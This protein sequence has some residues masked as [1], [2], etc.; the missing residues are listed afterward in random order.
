MS[1]PISPPPVTRWQPDYLPAYVANGVIGLR[2]GPVPHLRGVAIVSGFEG[3]DSTELI[4]SFARAPYPVAADL[5]VGKVKLSGSPERATLH[6]QRYDFAA[7]ELHTRMSF[8]GDDAR[9]EVDVLT[10][11]SRTLPTIALQEIVVRVDRDCDLMLSAGVDTERLPGTWGDRMINRFDVDGLLRWVSYGGTG[12]CGAAYVTELSGAEHAGQTVDAGAAAPLNTSYTIRA[13]A[14]RPY[15]LRQLTSLVPDALHRQ[16]HLQAVRLAHA[17]RTRGFDELRRDNART[18]DDLWQGRVVLAGAPRR[19]QAMAD[20][21][22]FYL[23]TSVHRSSP[24][25][26]GLFGMAY[27]PDYHYYRGHVMWDIE[28]F[29]VPSLLLTQPEAARTLLM[30]RSARLGGARA[31]AAMAGFGGLHFPWESSMLVGEEASPL[32]S[33]AP[34]KEHHVGMGVALAFARYAHATGDRE[35]AATHTWPV[36]D[37]VAEWI[38]SRLVRT[39]RGCEIERVN[40][41]AEIEGTV[42]NNAFV[43]MAAA[44]VLREAAA[45]GHALG[46][47]RPESWEK[48]AVDMILPIDP[49]TGVIYNHDGFDPDAPKA[50]T[51][52]APAGLVLV[53][54]ETD[55]ET[56]RRTYDYYLRLAD[57]YVGSPMLSALLGVFAARLGD[58]ALA[59]EMFERGYADF[60]VDPYLTTLEYDPAVFPEETRAGPFSANLGGFLTACLYGLPGLELNGGDPAGWARRPI[61]MPDG[62][63]AVTVARTWVRG[64]AATLTAEHGAPR[65]TL[66]LS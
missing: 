49:T 59:L 19:W 18:W 65:A 4:T 7:G 2:V 52:E 47:G 24:S 20:A 43:N 31:N 30:Y 5:R 34:D 48:S 51:P 1:T 8:D 42:D 53:G 60:V 61:T 12:S 45:F 17:A 28:T 35:F 57:R 15:R 64:Q 26:T 9:A 38:E 14:G 22:Y 27:W 40:G 58:R 39:P 10:F 23:H 6:E 37:G 62:W 46:R 29:V 63:D 13:R 33:P 44:V 66:L 3:L 36:L 50:A 56:E 55:P 41:I 54:F 21:A 16:P 11:C 32:N 25:S